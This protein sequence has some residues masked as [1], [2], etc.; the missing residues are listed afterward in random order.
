MLA[1]HTSSVKEI[2][3]TISRPVLLL[4][5]KMTTPW[6]GSKSIM[7]LNVNHMF[8]SANQEKKSEMIV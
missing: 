3:R 7:M 6:S 2:S 8:A 4:P 5:P 1:M